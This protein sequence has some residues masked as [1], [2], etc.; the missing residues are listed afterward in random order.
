[1][2]DRVTAEQIEI[3]RSLG[4]CEDALINLQNMTVDDAVKKYPAWL[5]MYAA[6]RLTD[7]QF[8]T[9]AEADPWG[10]LMSA[11]DRLTDEQFATAAAGARPWVALRYAADRLTDDQFETAAKAD[12][13]AARMYAPK[14]YHALQEV[15]A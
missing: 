14:R 9:A 10:A 11:A 1:M 5:I 12:P 15:S 2:T 3:A 13:W 8:A 6:D 7:E 4:A